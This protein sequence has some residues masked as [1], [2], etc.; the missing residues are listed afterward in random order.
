[1]KKDK[2]L[3]KSVRGAL[4]GF[5]LGD[6]MGA[7]TEFMSKSEIAER[8]G[9]VDSVLGG[10]WLCLNPGDVTD[11]TQMALC[12]ACALRNTLEGGGGVFDFKRDCACGFVDW[13][14]SNPI[15]VGNQCAK[16]IR[17]YDGTQDYIDCDSAALGNGAL[18]R[19]VPCAVLGLHVYNVQQG[20][21]THNNKTQSKAVETFSKMLF[22]LVTGSGSISCKHALMEPS[23]HVMNTLCNA[24]YWAAQRDFET[25]L[26]GAVNDGGDADTIG[27]LTGALAGARFGVDSIPRRWL[28]SLD[29]GVYVELARFAS[30]AV[31]YLQDSGQVL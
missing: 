18:M 5:A 28:E 6:A 29:Y 31:S 1:M 2:R 23:G 24:T 16:A 21:I 25:A 12:V 22:G 10:G 9:V 4:L 14:A 19:A 7:T 8:Y 3:S 11:D 26:K 13:L 20:M 15:D 30:F 27:A 17:Y